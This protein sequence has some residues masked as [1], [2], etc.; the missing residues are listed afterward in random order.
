MNCSCRKS[1]IELQWFE[2]INKCE[3]IFQMDRE[4]PTKL[5]KKM[6]Y[7]TPNTNQ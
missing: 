4:H 7:I 5:N 1:K 2:V 6:E 3:H